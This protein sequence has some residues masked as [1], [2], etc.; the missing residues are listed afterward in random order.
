MGLSE[1]QVTSCVTSALIPL[2]QVD[3]N[4][5]GSWPKVAGM[6]K[7]KTGEEQVRDKREDVCVMEDGR[8]MEDGG[9]GIN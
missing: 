1:L 6:P 7:P 5:R 4:K 9:R 8:C 2:S 3:P